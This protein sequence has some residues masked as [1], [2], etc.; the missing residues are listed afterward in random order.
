MQIILSQMC[1]AHNN[2]VTS[3]ISLRLINCTQYLRTKRTCV[4]ESY[5]L[6]ICT[7]NLIKRRRRKKVGV[8]TSIESQT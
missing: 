2:E 6:I 3:S 1:P 5:F 7:E 4:R 8:P